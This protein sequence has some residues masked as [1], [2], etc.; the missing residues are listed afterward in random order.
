VANAYHELRDLAAPNHVH[1]L[2][3]A[4]VTLAPE[5]PAQRTAGLGAVGA[6]VGVGG[7]QMFSLFGEALPAARLKCFCGI[8]D[9]T[10]NLILTELDHGNNFDAA[11]KKA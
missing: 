8:S 6:R 3:E 4:A 11:V 2:L 1:L 10:T 5:L 9:S 7:A